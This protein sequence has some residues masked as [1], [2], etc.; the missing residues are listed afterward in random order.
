MFPE[1]KE[2]LKDNQ[3]QQN[4][5]YRAINQ[6]SIKSYFL[7]FL[8]F[9][10]IRSILNNQ[11]KICTIRKIVVTLQ[12]ELEKSEYSENSEYSDYSR[13]F[14]IARPRVNNII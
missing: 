6:R 5:T 4:A 9:R 10:S 3:K 7:L 13:I 1:Y 12:S 14:L 8:F 11:K 2:R